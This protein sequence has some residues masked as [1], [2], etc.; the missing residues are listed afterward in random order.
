MTIVEA[1]K[2]GKKF[3]RRSGHDRTYYVPYTLPDTDLKKLHVFTYDD[4][5]ADDWIIEE[6]VVEITESALLQ[7]VLLS[8]QA[9]GYA[10]LVIDDPGVK[11]FAALLWK[12]LDKT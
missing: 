12:H 8:Q 4:V 7:A 9:R 6:P 10:G 5:L 2:S 3:R 11:N 1:I